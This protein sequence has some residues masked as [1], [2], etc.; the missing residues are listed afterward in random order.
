MRSKD[1][2]YS[3]TL[4]YKANSLLLTAQNDFSLLNFLEIFRADVDIELLVTFSHDWHHVDHKH[5][6]FSDES[7][8]SFI[9]LAAMFSVSLLGWYHCP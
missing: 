7:S 4:Q 3:V 5:I 9:F 8:N 2:E 6:I 1:K